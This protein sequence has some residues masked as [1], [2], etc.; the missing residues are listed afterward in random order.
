MRLIIGDTETTGIGP[1]KEPVEIAMMEID[2][3]LNVQGTASSLIMPRCAI[4]PEAQA[5]HGISLEALQA[6]NAPR[7]EQWVTDA[8]GGR[9]EG[10]VTLIG[11]RVGFDRP[12]FAPVCEVT[13]VLDTLPLAFEYVREA[14]DK[15][16]GTLKSHLGFPSMGDQHRAM[17]DVW[18]VYHLLHYLC[19]VTGRSLEELISTPYTVHYMPWGKHEGKLLQEVP[20]SYREYA[21]REFKDLDSNLR[22]SLEQ[23]ALMDPPRRPVV[24]GAPRPPIIISR[25][26]R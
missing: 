19:E 17:S 16:L 25:R 9:L 7:I 11:H 6:A 1:D 18:D 2:G 8:F 22:R 13:R 24:V 14:A 10:E 23:V 20:R 12:L 21:L 4:S 3:D 15:K 5:V 26:T